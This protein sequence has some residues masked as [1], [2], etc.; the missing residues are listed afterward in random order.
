M[1]AIHRIHRLGICRHD[2]VW[3]QHP[4]SIAAAPQHPKK[5]VEIVENKKTRLLEA[6]KSA[7]QLFWDP[8]QDAPSMS[9]YAFLQRVCLKI[10]YP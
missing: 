6:A 10:V 2:M 3:L 9:F 8:I 5:Q 7:K 4:W 1:V